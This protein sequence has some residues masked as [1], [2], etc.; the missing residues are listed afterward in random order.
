MIL[1]HPTTYLHT[2]HLI[3]KYHQVMDESE[4][5]FRQVQPPWNLTLLSLGL[6][7]CTWIPFTCQKGLEGRTNRGHMSRCLEAVNHS[8][9]DLMLIFPRNGV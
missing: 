2:H 6:V 3:S 9:M 4:G 8:I 5:G 1:G 7:V